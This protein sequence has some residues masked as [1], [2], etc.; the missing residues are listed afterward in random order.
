MKWGDMQ[1]LIE[2]DVK[3]NDIK[4][5]IS[6]N[7]FP[8]IARSSISIRHKVEFEIPNFLATS[9]CSKPAVFRHARGQTAA[10]TVHGNDAILA[11]LAVLRGEAHGLARRES[12]KGL[13]GR[14]SLRVRVEMAPLVFLSAAAPARIVPARPIVS[15]RR[16]NRR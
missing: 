3:S 7:N 16:R 9:F 11:S 1:H 12:L 15:A 6:S 5:G 2:S 4:E 13:A 10:F 8:V 14:R